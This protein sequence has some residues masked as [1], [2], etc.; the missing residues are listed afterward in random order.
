MSHVYAV[1]AADPKIKLIK[2][3][4]ATFTINRIS[5][6][7]VGS[8]V[9][10]MLL[11]AWSFESKDVALQVEALLHAEFRADWSHGEWFACRLSEVEE[12][13]K[14]LPFVSDEVSFKSVSNYANATFLVRPEGEPFEPPRQNR[15][16]PKTRVETAPKPQRVRDPHRS[17]INRI[18]EQ[19]RAQSA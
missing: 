7:Q 14:S 2:I 3:G 18:V 15:K 12:H 11:K 5:D 19:Y 9:R 6:L 8:P 1:G 4:Y 16:R 13:I 17:V 10:L